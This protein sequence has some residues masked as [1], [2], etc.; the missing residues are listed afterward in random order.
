LTAIS[1]LTEALQIVSQSCL[2]LQLCGLTARQLAHNIDS[3]LLTNC[4]YLKSAGKILLSL[5]NQEKI[6][7]FLRLERVNLLLL[8]EYLFNKFSKLTIFVAT[9]EW[10]KSAK[11]FGTKNVREKKTSEHILNNVPGV[12][13]LIITCFF[14]H[15]L[16]SDHWHCF[17]KAF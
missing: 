4:K 5:P 16:K 14:S 9:R 13:I 15:R 17:K 2:H 11:L 1:Y 7:Y 3:H 6:Q 12:V 10:R 8:K